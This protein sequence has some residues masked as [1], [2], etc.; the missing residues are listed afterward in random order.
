MMAIVMMMKKRLQLVAAW[1]IRSV[2]HWFSLV[3]IDGVNETITVSGEDGE[4]TTTG[5]LFEPLVGLYRRWWWNGYNFMTMVYSFVTMVELA[6]LVWR[7]PLAEFHRRWA[8]VGT[9]YWFWWYT[10]DRSFC[11]SIRRMYG[12][13]EHLGCSPYSQHACDTELLIERSFCW[14]THRGAA[15]L[16]YPDQSE[17]GWSHFWRPHSGVTVDVFVFSCVS[18]SERGWSHIVD[19]ILT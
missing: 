2:C 1:A 8:S 13:D 12:F 5:V 10:R 18:R 17:R 11:P 19:P 16:V 4:T 3:C 14:R 15:H 6:Q 9:M 7:G